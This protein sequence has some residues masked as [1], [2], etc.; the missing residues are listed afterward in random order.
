MKLLLVALLTLASAAQA[1]T[2]SGSIA[3]STGTTLPGATVLLTARA[4]RVLAAFTTADTS[5]AFRLPAVAPGAYELRVSFL[6]FEPLTRPV[7]VAAGPV[8]M[9]RLVLRERQSALGELRVTGRRVPVVVRS[10]TLDYDAGAFEVRPG[11][12]VEALLA[13]MPGVEVDA[14]GTVR[15]QGRVVDRVTVD[16]RDFFGST[17]SIA[18]RN[19]PADAVDRVQIFDERPDGAGGA[20]GPRT[21]NLELREDRR[22]GAFGRLEGG[23]GSDMADPAHVRYAGRASVNRFGPKARLSAIGSANN[24]NEPG[25]TGREYLGLVGTGDA[26]SGDIIRVDSPVLLDADDIRGF[27]SSWTGGANLTYD[28]APG[29]AVQANYVGYAAR[30]VTASKTVRERPA[31]DAGTTLETETA[32]GALTGWVHRAEAHADR[33]FGDGHTFRVTTTLDAQGDDGDSDVARVAADVAGLVDATAYRTASS[34]ENARLDAVYL[35][36]LG[37]RWNLRA[38]ADAA[39]GLRDENTRSDCLACTGPPLPTG[40]PVRG[41]TQSVVARA[42]ATRSL[43]GLRSV[44]IRAEQTIDVQTQTRRD[45]TAVSYRRPYTATAIGTV[46]SGGTARVRASVGA[47]LALIQRGDLDD[48]GALRVLPAATLDYTIALNQTVRLRYSARP[49]PTP[50]FKLHAVPTLLNPFQ[51]HI[52]NP[53]LRDAMLHSASVQYLDINLSGGTTLFAYATA[54]YGRDAQTYARTVDAAGITTLVPVNAG[55]SFSL[56]ASGSYERPLPGLAV[57]ATLSGSRSAATQVV[58]GQSSP[59]ATT[60][61]EADLRLRKRGGALRQSQIG[62]RATVQALSVGSGVGLNQTAARVNPYGRVSAT[63]DWGT[64]RV[65]LE[66]EVRIGALGIPARA[67]LA[68]IDATLPAMGRVS[69]S[70][71]ASDLLNGGAVVA[72]EITPGVAETSRYETLGRRLVVR[73]TTTF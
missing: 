41:T 9:G 26:Q 25:L 65:S 11:A 64:L 24:V 3:D 6:G 56:S 1:Q 48:R 46:L 30:T 59:Y 62:L 50:V 57:R 45:E 22:N 33:T 28:A 8:D 16:G 20:A 63:T 19:L 44:Q 15:A 29:T 37:G 47:D 69:A 32:N 10:D 54:T 17:P 67:P 60:Q 39:L 52:G 13:E 5:G 21:L 38:E 7:D 55:D 31:A 70:L 53:A 23:G 2:V 18:T 73:L 40:V 42:A 34:R 36:P 4:D 12:S 71:V 49:D 68:E 14:D 43:G 66:Q 72:Q 35:R 51:V 58:N 27:S 61:A